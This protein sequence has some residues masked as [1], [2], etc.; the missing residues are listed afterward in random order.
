MF[1]MKKGI[2]AA[3]ESVF[4]FEGETGY[5]PKSIAHTFVYCT[6][7]ALADLFY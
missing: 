6:S 1:L 4:H 5:A 7:K 3:K 2:I